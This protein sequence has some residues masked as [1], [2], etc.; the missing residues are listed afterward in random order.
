LGGT[1]LGLAIVK[2]LTRSMG[3]EVR[4][5]SVHGRGSTFSFTLTT[6]DAG[7][8]EDEKLQSEFTVL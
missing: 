4:V 3:G 6:Q 8:A 7:Q 1:G 5:E 2:H